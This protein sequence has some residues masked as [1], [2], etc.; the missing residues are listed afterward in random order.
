MHSSRAARWKGNCVRI[1]S[2]YATRLGLRT[3]IHYAGQH[4]H[5]FRRADFFLRLA[6]SGFWKTNHNMQ[7]AHFGLDRIKYVRRLGRRHLERHQCIFNFLDQIRQ[8]FSQHALITGGRCSD[9]L[10]GLIEILI[11]IIQRLKF[12]LRPIGSIQIGNAPFRQLEKIKRLAGIV[13]DQRGA[14][15]LGKVL[16][17]KESAPRIKGPFFCQC[18]SCAGTQ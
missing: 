16:E 7:R 6:L 12:T 5:E 8:L 17:G 11:Q 13:K 18:E 2:A 4:D 14:F 15:L 3:R 1:D 10:R 9:S